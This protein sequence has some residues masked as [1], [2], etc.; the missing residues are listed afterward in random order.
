MVANHKV[1]HP[2]SSRFEKHFDY[3]FNSF[4]YTV[5]INK[6]RKRFIPFRLTRYFYSVENYCQILDQ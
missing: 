5:K 4:R 3:G 2:V 1:A 6:V